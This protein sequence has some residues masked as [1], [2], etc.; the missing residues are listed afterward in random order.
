MPH[1]TK[2]LKCG[3]IIVYDNR[4][5][6]RLIFLKHPV[7][8]ALKT[9][10]LIFCASLVTACAAVTVIWLT[11]KVRQLRQLSL[12]FF[13]T[14]GI[15]VLICA[16]IAMIRVSARA[17]RYYSIY[18]K[19]L[20][21]GYTDKFFAYFEKRTKR[22][23]TKRRKNAAAMALASCYAEAGRYTDAVDTL[24]RI[25]FFSL[26]EKARAKYFNTALYIEIISGNT[27]EAEKIYAAGKSLLEKYSG[28]SSGEEI[29]S[30]I[31]ALSFARGDFYDAET[32]LLELCE[33]ALPEHVAS[34]CGIYL[35]MIYLQ[36]DRLE[37][38]KAAAEMTIPNIS[39][40]RDKQTMLRLMK[41][42]EN[43]YGAQSENA[44]ISQ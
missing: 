44:C 43:A 29:D 18:S 28:G 2:G 19:S 17:R 22:A 5:L 12:I 15:A 24:H 23:L 33:H 26:G 4:L 6:G 32:K 37:K 41:C 21:E 27:A 9:I 3:K 8:F 40:Y 30:T 36:T 7:L 16:A 10:W 25:D 20:E 14:F 13:N 34:A 31:A 1:F 38:A 35:T 39:S 42:I 11:G